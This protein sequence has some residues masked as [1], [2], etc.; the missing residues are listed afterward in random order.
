MLAFKFKKQLD[1]ILQ[2]VP[3]QPDCNGN[4]ARRAA[5][6]NS[7]LDQVI[8]RQAWPQGGLG[9]RT[10]RDFRYITGINL[11]CRVGGSPRRGVGGVTPAWRRRV[12]LAWRRR[13]TPAW[14]RRVTPAWR[15]R[16][17]PA[18][19]RRGHPSV[20][21]EGHPSVASEGQPGV[22]SEGHP[23]VASEGHPG[24]A[25]DGH[26]GVASEGHPQRGVGGSPPAWRRRG[27]RRV[28]LEWPGD[29]VHVNGKQ[30]KCI[31]C[32]GV[33]RGGSTQKT[34]VRRTMPSGP[35][36]PAPTPAA[37]AAPAAATAA[38]A[39]GTAVPAAATAAPAAAT[40]VP[41]AATAAPAAA[42]ARPGRET[43]ARNPPHKRLEG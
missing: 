25:S 12:S 40:A 14:R 9:S 22:A 33:N 5:P 3:D 41:A 38:P 6:S 8:A 36:P 16:V 19:R 4:V 35:C 34:G 13:V 10:P 39:A 17:T 43:A 29:A 42:T 37:T 28:T 2:E 32:N 20:A 24:V 1:K 11:A 26:P 21:S 30:R 31:S 15:R 18:W 27:H 23:S 7:L